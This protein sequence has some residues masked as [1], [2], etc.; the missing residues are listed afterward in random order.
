MTG[1]TLHA[2]DAS[3]REPLSRD[4]MQKRGNE[5]A[6]ASKRAAVDAMR[7]SMLSDFLGETPVTVPELRRW[8][9]RARKAAAAWQKVDRITSELT[10]ELDRAIRAEREAKR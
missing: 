4:E 1:R 2:V 5:L 9:D 7:A 6:R 10:D 8:R 3:E